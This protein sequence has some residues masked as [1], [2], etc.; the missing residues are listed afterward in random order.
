M[1]IKALYSNTRAKQI[2]TAARSASECF[3]ASGYHVKGYR[4]ALFDGNTGMD[5]VQSN[6]ACAK[7]EKTA[8]RHERPIFDIRVMS[9][10]PRIATELLRYGSR[11]EGP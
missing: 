4:L 6:R 5:N 9:A 2:W 10:S 3:L 1:V 11:R 7:T 8:K